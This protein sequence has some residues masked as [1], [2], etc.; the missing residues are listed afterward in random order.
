HLREI[1][2]DRIVGELGQLFGRQ[3]RQ[4]A[5]VGIV[6]VRGAG[7][8]SQGRAFAIVRRGFVD[9][10]DAQFVEGNQETVEFFGVYGLI[11]KVVVH[12]IVGQVPWGLGLGDQFV[13]TLC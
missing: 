10:L 12:L 6:L 3:G 4:T 2:A 1:H 7:S 9:Q 5:G 13:Q 8:D 11:G